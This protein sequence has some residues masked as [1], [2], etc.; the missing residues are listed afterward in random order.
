MTQESVQDRGRNGYGI[1][2]ED[3]GGSSRKGAFGPRSKDD[4]I[5]L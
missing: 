1:Y 5:G 4:L 3:S 2:T